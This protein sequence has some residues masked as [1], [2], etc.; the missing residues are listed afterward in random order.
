MLVV[1]P[2]TLAA[3]HL[4]VAGPS[5]HLDEAARSRLAITPATTLSHWWRH[6]WAGLFHKSWAHL[7]FN[8]TVFALGLT[9]AS[10]AMSPW[11]PL[12][13]AYWIGPF[14]VFA[15]HLLVILP[16]ATW[17]V[18]YAVRALDVPLV[19]F[20]VMAYSMA[21]MATTTLAPAAT[22]IVVGAVVALE[23]T[24][25]LLGATAPFVAVYH[26]AGFGLGF[27]VRTLLVRGP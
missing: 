18:P 26:L 27:W 23:L 5:G 19:G 14:T 10:R 4:V 2:V 15:I 24:V 11:V 21:G 9:V 17:N 13:N 12:G 1:I 22:W 16:L 20:S 3:V 7:A 6:L 25:G 8:V